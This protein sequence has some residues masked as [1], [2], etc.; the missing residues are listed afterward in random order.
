MRIIYF[1]FAAVA[2]NFLHVERLAAEDV[3]SLRGTTNIENIRGLVKPVKRA[4]ISS[5][6][7]G[8]ILEIRFKAGEHFGKGD[9]LVKF[10]CALYLAELE[11]AKAKFEAE[12]K[13]YENNKK[14]LALNAISDIEVD[15]SKAEMEMARADMKIKDIVSTHCF[16]KAPYNGRVIDVI[17]NEHESVLADQELMSILNDELLEIELIVPSNWLVKIKQGEQFVFSVDETR[18]EY[19]A[20]V[21]QVGAIVD[22]VS[23]TVR[24]RG[25]FTENVK[26]VLSGMSGTAIFK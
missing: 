6:I 5:E 4:V 25:K 3:V 9:L 12:E 19:P 8:R 1:L 26:D 23:Q 14:L 18:K 20:E 17:A 24:L 2:L 7:S 13:R 16:I 22:P 11:A 15:L 10:D 21:V